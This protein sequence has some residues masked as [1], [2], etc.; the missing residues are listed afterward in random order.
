MTPVTEKEVRILCIEY[1]YFIIYNFV[2]RIGGSFWIWI[3]FRYI[4][5]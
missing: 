2:I 4:W 3:K 1:N 5:F